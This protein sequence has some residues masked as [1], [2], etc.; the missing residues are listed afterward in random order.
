MSRKE[1]VIPTATLT[2]L[3]KT[4]RAATLGP[5][6]V[7]QPSRFGVFNPVNLYADGENVV[8]QV[9]GINLNTTLEEAERADRCVQGLANARF[10]CAAAD[11]ATGYLAMLT[12]VKRLRRALALLQTAAPLVRGKAGSR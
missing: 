1:A 5:Y 3:Q 6:T 12:E 2:Y 10:F 4:A 9:A 8:A 7:G 11:P